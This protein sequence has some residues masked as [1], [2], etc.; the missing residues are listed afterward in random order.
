MKKVFNLIKN[1]L[2][3]AFLVLLILFGNIPMHAYAYDLGSLGR[4]KFWIFLYF[5]YILGIILIVKKLDKSREK[6]PGAWFEERNPIDKKWLEKLLIFF[7]IFIG[8]NFIQ[9][10]I[11]DYFGLDPALNQE[12]VENEL[13]NFPIRLWLYGHIGLLAP[14]L[15]E[16]VFRKAFMDLFLTKD[17]SVNNFWAI[18][19][20]G[21]IFALMHEPKPSIYLVLYAIPGILLGYFY[22]STRD[23]RFPMLIHSANNLISII[24]LMWLWIRL[25]AGSFFLN[26]IF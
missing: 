3:F 8:F 22:R 11:M 20:S 2:I 12:M 6:N 15:E 9:S 17:N 7:L 13:I 18:F 21:F 4:P 25:C 1:I 14:I 23:L 5:I 24:A 26:T 19:L 16:L 10:L